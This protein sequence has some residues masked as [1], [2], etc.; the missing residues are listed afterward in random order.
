M[1]LQYCQATVRVNR[2]FPYI[3]ALEGA[4]SSELGGGNLYERAGK[5]YLQEYPPL[6]DLAWHFYVFIFPVLAMLAA[7]LLITWEWRELPYSLLDKVADAVIALGLLAVLFSYRI[8][9][10]LAQRWP[11]WRTARQRK[12]TNAVANT[13]DDSFLFEDNVGQPLR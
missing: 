2:H 13:E 10:T 5:I 4:L 3:H 8:H 9:P 1:A 7:L 6:L 12:Y 11:S